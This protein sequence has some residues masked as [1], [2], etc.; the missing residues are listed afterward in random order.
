L[1]LSPL[2]QVKQLQFQVDN[3]GEYG[4]I[5]EIKGKRICPQS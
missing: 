4:K 3:A 1:A 2:I 5:D